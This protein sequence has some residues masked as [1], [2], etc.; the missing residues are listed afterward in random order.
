MQDALVDPKW[1]KAMNEELEDLQKNSTW[2]LVPIP[3]G[4]KTVGCCWV[5]SVKLKADGTINRY[6]VRSVA[7]GYMQRYGIDYDETFAPVAKI[8]TVRILISI[9][10]S[11]DWPL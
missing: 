7:K 10:A 1:K 9:A 3:I 5:F 6:K 8:N 4:K 11:K 2:E